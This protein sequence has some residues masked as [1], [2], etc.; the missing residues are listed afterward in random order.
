MAL[1]FGFRDEDQEVVFFLFAFFFLTVYSMANGYM[2]G[3]GREGEGGFS[4][5]CGRHGTARHVRGG[6]RIDRG[7]RVERR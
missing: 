3:K 7:G 6:C 5:G 2:W 1:R 4:N